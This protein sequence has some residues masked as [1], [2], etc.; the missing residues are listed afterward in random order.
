L[1]RWVVHAAGAADLD[2]E[3]DGWEQFTLSQPLHGRA[4][5]GLLGN[6]P[7]QELFPSELTVRK[8]TL[9]LREEEEKTNFPFPGKPAIPH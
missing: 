7:F 9:S 8:R 5:G 6:S 4:E 3:G 1:H 2:I